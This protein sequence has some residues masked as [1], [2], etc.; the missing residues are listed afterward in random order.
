MERVT[1]NNGDKVTTIQATKEW[2][3]FHDTLA[4]NIF[5]TY[6]IRRNFDLGDVFSGF[7]FCF[8]C[9]IDSILMYV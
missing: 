8:L 7:G 6:Q 9:I 4:M 1:S 3:R 5:A 2:T